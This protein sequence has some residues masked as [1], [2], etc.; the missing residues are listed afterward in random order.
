M[1]HLGHLPIA[2]LGM[3]TGLPPGS[4]AETPQDGPVPLA[5]DTVEDDLRSSPA[6][7]PLTNLLTCM[8]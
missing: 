1:I 6:L 7:T 5:G 4:V 2:M 8:I 3:P